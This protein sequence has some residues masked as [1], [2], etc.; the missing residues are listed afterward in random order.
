VKAVR[1]IA[2]GAFGSA[3]AC[4]FFVP[5]SEYDKETNAPDAA[6]E[7]G[8][9]GCANGSCGA[10]ASDG[11]C[12]ADLQVDLGNCG[13]C[14]H[15]CIGGTCTAGLCPAEPIISGGGFYAVAVATDEA[16]MYFAGG[17]ASATF[18]GAI[19]V[20]ARN[21]G[22]GRIITV[23]KTSPV[24]ITTAGSDLFW[25]QGT[26]TDAG[27]SERGIGRVSK[28]PVEG[29]VPGPLYITGQ[30]GPYA[31]AAD[32]TNVFWSSPASGEVWTAGHAVPANE[33]AIVADPAATGLAI[34]GTSVYWSA[35]LP[36]G[37]V[38]HAPK[39]GGAPQPVAT[40]QITP[41]GLALDA[42]YVYW[43]SA[44]PDGAIFR[45]PKAGGTPFEIAHGQ[46]RPALLVVDDAYVYWANFGAET[47]TNGAIMRAAKSGGRALVLA[48]NQKPVDIAVDDRYVY[49][50][51]AGAVLR[52]PK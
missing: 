39:D 11:G 18:P 48:V 31:I 35:L 49:W 28:Y 19:G 10:D 5:F 37:H 36:V 3:A 12:D 6:A 16:G 4:S 33:R 1:L 7:S 43:A 17:V 9:D 51:S 25:T 44:D 14:G 22:E 29:G 8:S 15:A 52:V 32:E 26:F 41:A 20:V 42:E 46:N 45:A 50:A 47:S 30:A 21:S 34:D 2:A 13:A 23:T 40:S 27:V 38:M 24:R